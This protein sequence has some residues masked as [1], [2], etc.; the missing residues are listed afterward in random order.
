MVIPPLC[1][2]LSS[3]TVITL[4]ELVGVKLSEVLQD[5]G[6]PRWDRK[7]LA[8]LIIDESFH[9]LFDDGIFHGDPASGKCARSRGNRL[10]LLDFGLVGRMSKQMQESIIL[11]VL[12]VSLRDPDTVARL[13]YKVGI[14]DQRINLHSFR[15]DIHDI[16]ERYLGLKISE[17]DSSSLMRDLIDLALKYKIKI[18]KEYAVLSMASGT[19]EGTIRVLDPDLDVVQ[20]ALPYAKQLL[21]DRYNPTKMS[22]SGLRALLHLQGLLQDTPQQISQILMDLEGGK[23]S[24]SIKN[25]DLARI[26]SSLKSLA[27]LV[28]MGSISSGLDHRRIFTRGQNADSPTARPAGRRPR[29]SACRSRRCCS[30]RQSRG[31]WSPAASRSCRCDGG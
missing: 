25:D 11:L 29:W 2:E 4:G 12:S 21:F 23:F 19:T 14:P 9:Q 26:N 3:K 22:S 31:R 30:E 27:V 7:K 8:Q 28:F 17:V 5:P 1:Q 20:V 18:P 24:I 16:L 15:T 10:G 13:L 6:S